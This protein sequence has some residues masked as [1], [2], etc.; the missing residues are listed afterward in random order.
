MTPSFSKLLGPLCPSTSKSFVALSSLHH[1]QEPKHKIGLRSISWSKKV[2]FLA[3]G[4]PIAWQSGN[5]LLT[6]S[7]PGPG[8]ATQ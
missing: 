7:E 5:V 8:P 4:S 1:P 2:E 3:L 6:A